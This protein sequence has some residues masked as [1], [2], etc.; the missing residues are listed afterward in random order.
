MILDLRRPGL[1]YWRLD[2]ITYTAANKKK[3]SFSEVN[4]TRSNISFAEYDQYATLRLKTET[5]LRNANS[6]G[7][8]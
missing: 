3:V 8:Y 4:A 2:E 7:G 1:V 5:T 6:P